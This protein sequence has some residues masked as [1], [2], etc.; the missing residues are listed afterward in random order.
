MYFSC[1]KKVSKDFIA[2]T[3]FICG[4]HRTCGGKFG[5]PSEG[6]SQYSPVQKNLSRLRVAR[7]FGGGSVAGSPCAKPKDKEQDTNR[8]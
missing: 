2:L 1:S 5:F 7:N 8:T 4:Q 3:N 6:H